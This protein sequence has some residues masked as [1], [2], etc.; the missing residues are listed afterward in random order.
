MH[1]HHVT[2]NG[3]STF[4]VVPT[5]VA[6]ASSPMQQQQQQ[7]QKQTT[8]NGIY[9]NVQLQQQRPNVK[10][11]ETV[12]MISSGGSSPIPTF[13]NLSQQFQQQPQQQVNSQMEINYI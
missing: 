12:Q 10:S 2:S 5:S 11:E 1:P 7:S 8:P 9:H 13:G 6:T 4:Y 3:H